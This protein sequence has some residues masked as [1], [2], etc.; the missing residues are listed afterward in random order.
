MITTC[1]FDAYGT[2]FDVASAARA[3]GDARPDF[4]PH[5]VRVATTWRLKQLQYTWL[6]LAHAAVRGSAMKR[7]NCSGHIRRVRGRREE[8]C[9][10]E[11]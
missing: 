2:L 11:E 6:P 5:W 4:A 7:Q 10:E 8:E 1:I 9:E 3:V